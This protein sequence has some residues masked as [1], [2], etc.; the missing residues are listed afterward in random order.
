MQIGFVVGAI[1]ASYFD[2]PISWRH[3][4]SMSLACTAA[5]NPALRIAPT[6]E[7]IGPRFTTGLA[8][9]GGYPDRPPSILCRQALTW[10]PRR[11]LSVGVDGHARCGSGEFIEF[12]SQWLLI[13]IF[14]HC[15][16]FLPVHLGQLFGQ[17]LASQ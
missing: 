5:V 4:L 14:S 3:R 15:H 13:A 1:G 16:K 7:V 6:A 10:V 11:N 9:V 2:L 12:P 8:L 17:I